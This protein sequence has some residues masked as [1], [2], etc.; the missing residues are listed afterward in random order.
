[1]TTDQA[2]VFIIIA[3]LMILFVWGKIRYDLAA[4]VG[5]LGTI[6]T[7]VVPVDKAFGG[8]SDHVVIIVASA[9]IVST[10]VSKSGVIARLI[11]RA[12]PYMRTP[13]TQFSFSQPP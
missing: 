2:I 13:G 7:G 4:L 5:L 8:F 6:T 10:G 9:L 3:G 11:R 12:E 1:M